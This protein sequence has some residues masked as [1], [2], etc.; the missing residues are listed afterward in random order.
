MEN[1]PIADPRHFHA[2]GFSSWLG[3]TRRMLAKQNGTKVPCGKCNACCRA[4]YFIHIRPEESRTLAHI[5]KK[6]LFPTPFLPKGNLLLGYDKNGHCPMLVEGKCSIYAFRPLACRNYDC[7]IFHATDIAPDDDGNGLINKRVVRWKFTYPTTDDRIRHQAV[8]NAVAFIR[9]HAACFPNGAIPAK[10]SQLAILAIKVYDLFLRK[11]R[12]SS[13]SKRV[14]DDKKMVRSVIEAN[15]RFG[16]NSNV[17][18][19]TVK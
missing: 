2:G 6:L 18:M 3:R 5:P 7:R 9:E 1:N 10:A 11:S 8:K 4:S 19:E 14:A 15:E 17:T 16:L 12:S 13:K